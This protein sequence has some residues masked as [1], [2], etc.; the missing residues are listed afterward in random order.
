MRHLFLMCAML[1]GA[2]ST[3]QTAAN[4]PDISDAKIGIVS[5]KVIDQNA[6]NPI[7]YASVV[8]KSASDKSV[9]TGGITNEDGSFE[10][11]KIEDGTHIFE[12]QFIGYTT[13]TKTITIN[14]GNRRINM[15][16][17]SLEENVT[18]L[19]GVDVVAERSTIEQKI[20]R[21]VI[22][23]GKDL[24]TQGATAAEIMNNIPSVNVDQQTG[25]LSLRGNSNV[26]VMVDGKLSNV[27]VAQ[28]LRQI[29]STSIKKI[30]LITNPSAKYNPEGMSGLINIVLHKNANIGFNGNANIGLGYEIEAKF[31][32]SLDLNYRQ[33]KFNFYGSYGNNTSKNV[34][35]GQIERLD[36]PASSLN[37]QQFQ[38]FY[39]LN[40]NKS[41]LYKFGLDFYLNE[42]NTISMFTNQNT[43]DGLGNADT[44]VVNS[45]D[46]GLNSTQ[47]ATFDDYNRTEQYNFVYKRDFAKEGHNLILE[48]D[49]SNF[50]NTQDADFRTRGFSL[51]PDYMDFVGT[52][53]DQS[54]VNLDYVNPLSEKSKLELGLESRIFETEVDYASTGFSFDGNGNLIPTPSTN[55]IYGMDIY[56]AYATFGQNFGKWSYQVGARVED[57]SVIADTNGERTFTDDYFQVYPS[58]F[59]RFAPSEKNQYQ[60]SYSRR[61]DRPGLQQVNPVRE[62]STPQLSSFGNQSLLPQ[63]TNSFEVNYTHRMEKLGSISFGG[64][65]RQINDEINRAVFVDRTDLTKQILT[66]ENFADTEAYG[67]EINTNLNLTKWWSVNLSSEF[68]SQTQRG[69]T[70]RLDPS[71]VNPTPDDITTDAI[72]VENNILNLRMNNSFKATKKLSFNVFGLYRGRSATLQIEQRPLYFVNLGARHTFAQG[73]GS[74]SLNFNDIFNTAQWGFDTDRPYPQEGHFNWESRTI[75][76]GMSYQFG[77]GKNRAL[78]R[79]QRDS[80]TK[81]GGGIL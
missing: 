13:Y 8:I 46:P 48:A 23:I 15:G 32:G 35:I 22:N 68:F 28:L 26:R 34:N 42:K 31:N 2:W 5:G 63:F 50:D 71:I 80:N 77:S 65:F 76:V 55:F 72:Q 64:F 36:D 61:V 67:V 66:Y 59:V 6:K 43:F 39:F 54:I 58:A 16:T 79:K 74:V 11:K 38:Y 7:P 45:Q 4:E 81:S 19:E 51:V 9:L 12:I 37:E 24:T 10:I 60:V 69:L 70:E 17:I 44:D 1:F 78:R 40:N 56:S 20:D 33:G 41:N 57:V 62:W 25:A 29:P 49:Y 30:E 47:L 53:R 73:K 27:P 3:A 14:R 21:K 52:Q 18:E 75:F